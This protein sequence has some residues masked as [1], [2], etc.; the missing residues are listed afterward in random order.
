VFAV[1]YCA[2]GEGAAAAAAAPPPVACGVRCVARLNIP[3]VINSDHLHL[4]NAHPYLETRCSCAESE[5]D[6]Q[7]WLEARS[8]SS[9]E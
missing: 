9:K 2:C 8:H 1:V 4:H 3:T 7:G 6:D 5:R